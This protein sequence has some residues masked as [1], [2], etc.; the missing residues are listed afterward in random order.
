MFE[1]EYEMT[2]SIWDTIKGFFVGLHLKR[3]IAPDNRPPRQYPEE[4][5]YEDVA[6]FRDR[7]FERTSD[8]T[9][10]QIDEKVKSACAQL[11]G[12]GLWWKGGE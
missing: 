9:F 5:S 2:R 1:K 7:Y 12:K 11:K 3:S 10:A 4:K 8:P 6:R